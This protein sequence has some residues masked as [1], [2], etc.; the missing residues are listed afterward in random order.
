LLT[1]FLVNKNLTKNKDCVR[2]IELTKHF[3]TRT[4]DSH[5]TPVKI[6]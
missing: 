4:D 2:Y 3:A 6:Y 5:A 1:V